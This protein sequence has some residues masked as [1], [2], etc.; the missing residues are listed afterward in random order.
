MS[1][2]VRERER[3]READSHS[4]N[5]NFEDL[6]SQDMDHVIHTRSDFWLTHARHVHVR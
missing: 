1:E 3:E 2:R 5:I 4:V 6:L